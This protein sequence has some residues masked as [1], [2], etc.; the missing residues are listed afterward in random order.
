MIGALTSVVIKPLAGAPGGRS[1]PAG[2]VY[3][4]PQERSTTRIAANQRKYG[5]CVEFK[6]TFRFMKIVRLF[7]PVCC[8]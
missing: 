1:R 4:G 3:V 7:F 8:V 2:T 6:A 5:V